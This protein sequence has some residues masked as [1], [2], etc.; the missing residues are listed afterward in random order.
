MGDA[1][2]GKRARSEVSPEMKIPES[3]VSPEK[4]DEASKGVG[5]GKSLVEDEKQRCK[6]T[7]SCQEAPTVD[8]F[9]HYCELISVCLYLSRGGDDHDTFYLVPCFY[10]T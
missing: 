4:R 2:H 3:V 1:G 10:L 5:K 8:I 9:L 6:G 7:E